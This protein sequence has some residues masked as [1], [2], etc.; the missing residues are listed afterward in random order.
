[1]G[2]TDVMLPSD[3]SLR[4]QQ[5]SGNSQKAW[6]RVVEVE[7]NQKPGWSSL[8][9]VRRALSDPRLRDRQQWKEVVLVLFAS[10]NGEKQG[11]DNSIKV[12]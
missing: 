7:R 3:G 1:M 11:K 9:T 5:N 4:V 12:A 6:L 8:N 10:W 2:P